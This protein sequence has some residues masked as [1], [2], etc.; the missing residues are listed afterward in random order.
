MSQLE[1]LN[2]LGGSENSGFSDLTVQ[3]QKNEVSLPPKPP[4]FSHPPVGKYQEV[5]PP[6]QHTHT[7]GGT[8][9]FS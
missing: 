7:R 2:A 1:E 4:I 9:Y 5:S 3:P 8:G 6:L